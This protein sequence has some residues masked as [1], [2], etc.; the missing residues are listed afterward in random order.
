MTPFG[1]PGSVTRDALLALPEAMQREGVLLLFEM[2]LSV[3]AVCEVTGW[4]RTTVAEIVRRTP[5]FRHE[6]QTKTARGEA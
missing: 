6:S 1:R 3:G 2:G 5:V 4:S